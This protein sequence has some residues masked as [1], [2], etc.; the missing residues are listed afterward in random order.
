MGWCLWRETA[1][2]AENRGLAPTEGGNRQQMRILEENVNLVVAGAWNPAILT[3][4]WI[5]ERAM[6]REVGPNFQVQVELPT[7]NLTFR[8]ARPRFVFEGI[9][10]SSETHALT[11]RLPYD[12]EEGASLGITTAA[13]ILELLSH[14]PVSG[15]GI[16]FGFEFD[17]PSQALLDTFRGTGF[18]AEAIADVDAALVAQG[19]TGTVR[20]GERLITVAAQYQAN[21][22]VLNINVHTEVA[23]AAAAAAALRA[24][25]FFRTI[26]EQV[27]GVVNR[28]DNPQEAA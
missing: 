13:S 18:V 27:V 3:P 12:D 6:R 17:Q 2:G 4:N 28:F 10:V 11:F 23:S 26:K 9:S 22:V 8:G 20:T 25:H 21:V 7:A 24:E 5:A 1:L 15:F 19:W 14:T 16:N